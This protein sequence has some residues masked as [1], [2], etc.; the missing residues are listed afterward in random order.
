MV[1]VYYVSRQ[2]RQF[3]YERRQVLTQPSRE[4]FPY[5]TC[6]HIN[7]G[8]RFASNTFCLFWLECMKNWINKQWKTSLYCWRCCCCF[9]WCPLHTLSFYFPL[10]TCSVFFCI[11]S[12]SFSSTQTAVDWWR[13]LFI[14]KTSQISEK[15]KFSRN[16]PVNVAVWFQVKEK[17][18]FILTEAFDCLCFNLEAF[19][20]LTS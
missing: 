6:K 2:N 16:L 10:S 20:L 13:T 14:H 1:H 19:M 8:F 3:L 4:K 12:N 11:S 17:F 18:S 15:S 7:I 5:A 9:C